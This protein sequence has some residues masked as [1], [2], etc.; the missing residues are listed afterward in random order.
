MAD[1]EAKTDLTVEQENVEEPEMDVHE[2]KDESDAPVVDET[3]A[4]KAE[5]NSE[6]HGEAS[7]EH[8]E[9]PMQ[10]DAEVVDDEQNEKRSEPEEVAAGENEPKEMPEEVLETDAAVVDENANIPEEGAPETTEDNEDD[11]R[12]MPVNDAIPEEDEEAELIE[13][14]HSATREG[15]PGQA[16]VEPLDQQ[17][18]PDAYATPPPPQIDADDDSK[19]FREFYEVLKDHS[20]APY[21][22]EYPMFDRAQLI[23][24]YKE[25]LEERSQLDSTNNQLQ[26]KLA[27]YFKK[28]KTDERVQEIEKNVTDQEQRYLNFVSANLEELQNEEKRQEEEI[29]SL[30]EDL[31]LKCLERQEKVEDASDEYMKFKYDI[32]KCSINSRSGKP[33][34]IKDLEAFQ[35]AETKKEQEVI[36]VR[37]ENIKLKNRLRKKEQQLKAKEELAEGL[38]LIDFEQLKIENQTYNEKI[39]E[40]NEEILKLRKKITTTVQVLTHLKEKLQFVQGENCE[41]RT[42][43][44]QIESTVAQK[45]DILTRTKQVRDALRNDNI[46]LKQKCGLLGNESLL[47]DFELR[48]DEGDD[49]ADKLSDLKTG[50]FGL[51]MN[52]NGVKKKIRQ[53]RNNSA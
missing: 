30:I 53:A 48:K 36:Q 50:H 29:R 27:E 14:S 7:P 44:E 46:K 26:H 40:R 9:Q 21:S 25:A 4:E 32:T 17:G 3:E 24:R 15:T 23:E 6:A 19:E 35:A 31:K 41:Q 5:D 22:P 12:H 42:S 16:D 37:L 20:D 10:N 18:V 38:H 52:L 43:L 34:P 2:V 33:L 51:S 49:L 47:R 28:K 1:E 39:E 13:I 8:V 45:R 11:Q